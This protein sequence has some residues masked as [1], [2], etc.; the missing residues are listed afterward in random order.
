MDFILGL[1][2]MTSR[3]KERG[4]VDV[5]VIFGGVCTLVLCIVA[6]ISMKTRR[7][8]LGWFHQGAVLSI[9]LALLGLDVLLL[10]WVLRI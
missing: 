4:A 3:K 9:V 5:G 10:L 2:T 6:V 8:R 1:M 7:E